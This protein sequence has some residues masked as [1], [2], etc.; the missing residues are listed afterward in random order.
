M[1][2]CKICNKKSHPIS[3]ALRVCLE[4][5]RCSPERS[6]AHTQKA[7]RNS[8]KEFGLPVE[9]PDDPKGKRCSLCANDCKLG[10]GQIGFCGLRANM[11]GKITGA[12]ADSA[13]LS[14]YH[15]PL[16]TN[17]V[18]DWVC[19]GG[20]GAGYPKFAHCEGA[21]RGYDNLAV[22]F[23]A[24]SFNCL[25]CQNWHFRKQ[26]LSAPMTSPE[27]LTAEISRN[28]ACLCFFGGDPS[29]QLP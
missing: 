12:N 22:F 18:G 4:C 11:D 28:T 6:L 25:F 3:K 23:H 15:D 9:A 16:P 1:T 14:W 27:D 19:P 5:I 10:M 29:P 21:E 8:R 2:T 26:S 20:T 13:N 24:C 7:H 17:C